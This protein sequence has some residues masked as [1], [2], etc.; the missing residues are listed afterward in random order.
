VGG[1]ERSARRKRQQQTAASRAVTSARA[2]G[3]D[4]TKLVVG[5]VV[6]LLLAGAVV[7]GVLYANAQKNKTAGRD[8]VVQTPTTAGPSYPVH[9]DGVVVVAG[10]DD[11]KVTIDLYEDFLC[12]ICRAFE[13]ANKSAMEQKMQDGSL[14]V[15]YHM[16]AILNDRSDPEG[17][18][19][20]AANAALCIADSGR[21][22]DYHANLYNAQPEEG[23]RG[24]DKGQLAKLGT[25]LGA[26]NP[27]L[28]SCI[29]SGRY[30]AQIQAA[31]NEATNTPYLQQDPGN[32]KKSFGTPTVAIG[33]RMIDTSDPQW[34]NKLL[35]AS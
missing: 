6:V 31:Q 19:L 21:F 14:R 35:S 15:R 4:R 5:L 20:D 26:S 18:S 8:I 27:D 22:P 28:K 33:Q 23:A 34:L 24:Y 10:K 17:Y 13:Q 7:G 30:N 2:S 12:P 9:R 11:A 29:D 25:D 32:G 3:T 1:A 16:L